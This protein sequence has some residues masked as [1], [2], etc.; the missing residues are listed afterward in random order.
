MLENLGLAAFANLSD[1]RERL[2]THRA[3]RIGDLLPENLGSSASARRAESEPGGATSPRAQ[4]RSGKKRLRKANETLRKSPTWEDAPMGLR[5]DADLAKAIKQIDNLLLKGALTRYEQA[6][7]NALTNAVE[8]YENRAVQMPAILDAEMLRH[9]IEANDLTQ[10]KLAEETGIAVSTIS[11]SNRLPSPARS[12]AGDGAPDRIGKLPGSGTETT[13]LWPIRRL[14]LIEGG[15]FPVGTLQSSS[16]YIESADEK[17]RSAPGNGPEMG[18]GAL[19]RNEAWGKTPT[20][21][22]RGAKEKAAAL[23]PPHRR[24]SAGAVQAQGANVQI[25]TDAA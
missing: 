23:A 25:L 12:A 3:R 24:A 4:K 16:A 21:N 18:E 7:L 13:A 9:L 10:V 8:K 14:S 11:T 19:L 1:V 22:M 2:T 6:L 20:G 5:F 15:S 17:S